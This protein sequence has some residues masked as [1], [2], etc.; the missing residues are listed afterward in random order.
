MKIELAGNLGN[1]PIPI[2]TQMRRLEPA[3]ANSH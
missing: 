3:L 2:R 1:T